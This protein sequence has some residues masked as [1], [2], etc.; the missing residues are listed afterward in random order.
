[1]DEQEGVST[2]EPTMEDTTNQ[3]S[4]ADVSSTESPWND[5]NNIL[6]VEEACFLNPVCRE[7]DE[8]V[9]LEITSCCPTMD[10]IFLDCCAATEEFCYD[11]SGGIVLCPTMSTS[12]YL[13]EVRTGIRDPSGNAL[14]GEPQQGS[15]ATSWTLT[16]F[17]LRPYYSVSAVVLLVW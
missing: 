15:S 14:N 16:R 4:I 9:E 6:E 10:G 11:E 12:Q 8:L 17:C 5:E 3:P 1:M 7:R 2:S 13:A